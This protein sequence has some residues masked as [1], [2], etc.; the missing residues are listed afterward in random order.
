MRLQ[1]AYLKD[2]VKGARRVGTESWGMAS[3]GS[4][5]QKSSVYCYG[6]GV[7]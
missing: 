5:G 7:V 4:E 2:S 3:E 6:L 1:E